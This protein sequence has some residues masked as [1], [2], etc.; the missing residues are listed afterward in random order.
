V[1]KLFESIKRGLEE[2]IAFAEEKTTGT[3][4]HKPTVAAEKPSPQRREEHEESRYTPSCSSCLCS[5]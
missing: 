3:Q 1:S 2:A 5:E 4:V